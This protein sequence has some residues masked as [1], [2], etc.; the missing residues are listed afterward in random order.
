MEADFGHP[1]RP[2]RI[3]KHLGLLSNQCAVSILRESR[4]KYVHFGG[5]VAPILF[6]L[7]NDPHETRNLAEDPVYTDEISRMARKMID[8][9]CE[10]RDR[11]LTGFSFGV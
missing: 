2:T 8:R 11:R 4:W 6:D 5:G 7:V 10:R 9:M 3:Q 1:T